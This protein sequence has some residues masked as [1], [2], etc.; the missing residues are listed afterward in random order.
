MGFMLFHSVWPPTPCRELPARARGTGV[1]FLVTLLQNMWALTVFLARSCVLV[2]G[3]EVVVPDSAIQ[4]IV[5]CVGHPVA[6]NPTQFMMQR[7]LADVGLDWCCLTL[8]VA[9]DGS[10]RC[11]PGNSGIWLQRGESESAAQSGCRPVAGRV[12]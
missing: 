9:P 11:D 3:S 1:A 5:C 6:G 7:A 2:S 8:E 4:E 12:E 10:G